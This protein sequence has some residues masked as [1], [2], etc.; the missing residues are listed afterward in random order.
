MKITKFGHIYANEMK[1]GGLEIVITE[2][3]VTSNKF[4][5]RHSGKFLILAIIKTLVCLLFK[6]VSNFK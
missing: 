2:F 5:E 6:P 1:S 3:E 4:E